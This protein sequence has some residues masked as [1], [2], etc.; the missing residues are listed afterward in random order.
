M[1]EKELEEAR[2]SCEQIIDRVAVAFVGN[3]LLLLKLLAAAF[4]NGHVLFEYF[5]GLGK[6]LLAKVFARAIGGDTKRVQ[7]TPDLLP[8]DILG[9]N[10][11]RQ[12]DSTFQMMPGPVFT[13]VL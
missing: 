5:P 4:A 10:V 11:W 9:M 12:K 13:N 8:S 1:N 7:F 3:R 6:T 2:L